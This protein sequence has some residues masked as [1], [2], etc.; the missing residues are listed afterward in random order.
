M[1]E[2]RKFHWYVLGQ[3]AGTAGMTLAALMACGICMSAA[4]W[5]AGV[6]LLASAHHNPLHAGLWTWWDALLAYRHGD[7]PKQ[8]RHLAGSLLMG[9]LV[10]F[11]APPA[12]GYALWERTGHRQL[13]GSARFASGAE[14]RAAGLL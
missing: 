5:L 11:G 6:I 3:H 9:C 7:L 8:G 2:K 12:A 4:L 13:Y 14:I 1:G 10:V